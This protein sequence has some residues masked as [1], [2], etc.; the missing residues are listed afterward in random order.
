[1]TQLFNPSSLTRRTLII[2]ILTLAI[3][4]FEIFN[5]DTT[6]FALSQLLGTT[7]FW[8]VPWAAILAIAFC[9]IDFAG[10]LHIFSADENDRYIWYMMGAWLMGATLNAIMTW[11][12]VLT[13]LLT[14]ATGN[15]I[16][17]RQQILQLAPIFVALLVWLTRIFFIGGM[18]VAGDK[19]LADIPS[20]YRVEPNRSALQPARLRRAPVLPDREDVSDWNESTITVAPSLSGTVVADGVRVLGDGTLDV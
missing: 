6:R 12:A 15:E 11:Y 16:I 7:S 19:V 20:R 4:A 17:S 3:F 8:G 5:F 1:M 18:T 2:A 13:V 14:H 10:L 9:S